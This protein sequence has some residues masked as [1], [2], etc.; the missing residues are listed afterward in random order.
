MTNTTFRR[1]EA[2]TESIDELLKLVQNGQIIIPIFQRNFVWEKT[3]IKNIFDSIYRGYPIGNLQ[4]QM[5]YL[6]LLMV[7]NV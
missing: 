4:N 7:N 2:R 3:D 1:P 5:I 6:L